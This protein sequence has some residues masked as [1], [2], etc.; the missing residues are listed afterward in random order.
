VHRHDLPGFFTATRTLRSA[1]SARLYAT[2]INRDDPVEAKAEIAQLESEGFR[3]GVQELLLTTTRAEAVSDALVFGSSRG[4]KREFKS[5]LSEDLRTH[6]AGLKRFRIAGIPGSIGLSQFVSRGAGATTDVLFFT[7]RCFF[8]VGTAV[9]GVV[10]RKQAIAGL[11]SA[12]RAL[13]RRARG[14]CS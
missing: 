13:Y 9:P 11:V 14:I 1:R 12:A 7:G 3:E 2:V 5:N 10:T 4:A 6:H 8:L